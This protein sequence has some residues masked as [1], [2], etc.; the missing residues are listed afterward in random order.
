MAHAIQQD[1]D[2]VANTVDVASAQR[3]QRACGRPPRIVDSSRDV[4][5]YMTIAVCDGMPSMYVYDGVIWRQG[6]QI[7]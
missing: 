2:S 1:V 4:Y 3:M 7:C 6:C 5:I